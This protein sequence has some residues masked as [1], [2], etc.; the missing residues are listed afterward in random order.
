MKVLGSQVLNQI[1]ENLVDG[2]VSYDDRKLVYEVLLD[3]FEDFGAKNLDEC[4]DIDPAFDEI[5]NEKYPP[6]IEEF[7][8]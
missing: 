8:E 5:W 3:I 2:D 1:C 4:L 6:E 7:D